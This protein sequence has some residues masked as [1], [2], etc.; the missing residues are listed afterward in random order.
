MYKLRDISYTKVICAGIPFFAKNLA[1]ITESIR[2][3][4]PINIANH[5]SKLFDSEIFKSNN[6]NA[7]MIVTFIGRKSIADNHLIKIDVLMA[8]DRIRR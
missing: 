4:N 2:P 3:G 7:I 1:E 8:R 5:F 6:I